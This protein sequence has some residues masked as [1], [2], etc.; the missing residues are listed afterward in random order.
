MRERDLRPP[1]YCVLIPAL[2]KP[3][4]VSASCGVTL[5]PNAT[6]QLD[7][8]LRRYVDLLLDEVKPLLADLQRDT[9]ASPWMTVEQ[10]T[11]YLQY[12]TVDSVYRLIDEGIIPVVRQTPRRIL[13]DREEVDSTLR[14]LSTRASRG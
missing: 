12:R 7:M 14:R 11:N 13:I 8:L 6:P 9:P 4:F 3:D 5:V 10:C 1:L 2:V